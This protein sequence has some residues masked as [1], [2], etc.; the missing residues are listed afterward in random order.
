MINAWLLYLAAALMYAAIGGFTYR[1]MLAAS[2]SDESLSGV[3]GIA[4][5]LALAVWAVIATLVAVVRA[6][7]A[8][9]ER[10]TSWRER[11]RSK[12]PRAEVRK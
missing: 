3:G 2:W 8:V 9:G 6:G 5:P 1:M 7:I 11:R 4:W 10:L 12:L